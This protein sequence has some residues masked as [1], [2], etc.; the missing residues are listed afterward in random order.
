MYCVRSFF[1]YTG[2]MFIRENKTFNKKTQT[3]YVT[4]RLVE[5]YQTDKG[6]RQR[7]I[8]HLGVLDTPKSQW[9]QLA[10]ILE[11][12]L[13]GQDSFIEDNE[14]LGIGIQ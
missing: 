11:A 8:M 14:N 1:P 9:R 12:R 10:A 7:V 5:S 3:E 6:P 4:H 2:T 13:A